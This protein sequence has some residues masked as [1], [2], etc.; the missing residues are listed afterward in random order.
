M[1][2]T[3]PIRA[4]LELYTSI[5][6]KTKYDWA[7]RERDRESNEIGDATRPTFCR[8]FSSRGSLLLVRCM[9]SFCKDS[10]SRIHQACLFPTGKSSRTARSR[11][12]DRESMSFRP[13]NLLAFIGLKKT[14]KGRYI[15]SL[16]SLFLRHIG[17]MSV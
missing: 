1:S 7:A 15:L 17:S 9:L 5:F 2:C 13:S 14:M 6:M 12:S 3:S 10:S 16:S 4:Y 8:R 11:L